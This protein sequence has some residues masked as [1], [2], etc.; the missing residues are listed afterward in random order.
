MGA[1]RGLA[2]NW[3]IEAP[4]V[5]R[6]EYYYQ[7]KSIFRRCHLAILV[8]SHGRRSR[9]SQTPNVLGLRLKDV[10]SGLSQLGS[11]PEED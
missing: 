2:A 6:E 10:I 1:C 4:G 3:T 8:A 7:A 11:W 9:R 5:G